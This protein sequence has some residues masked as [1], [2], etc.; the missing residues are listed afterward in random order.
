MRTKGGFPSHLSGLDVF[1]VGS[2]NW[3]F[4]LHV[5]EIFQWYLK[6]VL[7]Y[8]DIKSSQKYPFILL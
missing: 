8:C 1:L 7:F 5:N 2:T 3:I 6:I 4:K